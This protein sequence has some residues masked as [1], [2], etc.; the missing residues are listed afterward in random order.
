MFVSSA[1]KILMKKEIFVF[2]R[3]YTQERGLINAASLIAIP[4]SE[5]KDI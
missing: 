3:E 2:I 4:L 5:L 1:S